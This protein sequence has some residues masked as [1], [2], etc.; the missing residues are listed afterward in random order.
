MGGMVVNRSKLQPERNHGRP[1]EFEPHE[2]AVQIP[3]CVHPEFR[4]QQ[5]SG[6]VKKR[7]G[8]VFLR[9]ADNVHMLINS[10]PN[11]SVSGVTG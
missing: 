3:Y 5:L 4:R 6:V 11:H 9:L 1:P 8:E 10:P 2:V 7:L